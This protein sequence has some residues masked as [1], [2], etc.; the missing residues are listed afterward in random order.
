MD[1]LLLDRTI[2]DV[3]LISYLPNVTYSVY[4]LLP[5]YSKT[6]SQADTNIDI[7][8]QR[9]GQTG[10]ATTNNVRNDSTEFVYDKPLQHNIGKEINK[11]RVTNSALKSQLRLIIL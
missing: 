3:I 1:Y 2:S 11:Q 9:C 6:I 8:S 7:K 10:V 4:S 5:A